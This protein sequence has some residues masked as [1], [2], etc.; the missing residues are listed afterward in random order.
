MLR[1]LLGAR[2]KLESVTPANV[3]VMLSLHTVARYHCVCRKDIYCPEL[4]FHYGFER[5]L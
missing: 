5:W 4:I 3:N 2:D 1:R